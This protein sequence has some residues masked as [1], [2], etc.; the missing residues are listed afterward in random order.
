M[1]DIRPLVAPRSIAVIG[2]STNAQKS[3]GVLFHNL[4]RGGFAGPLYPI[5]PN[6]AEVMGRK[7]YASLADVPEHVDLVY[8][9][10]PRDHV[11][12]A[13]TQ[14]IAAGARAASIITAGFAEA[15]EAGRVDQERIRAMARGAGLLLG[16]PNTIGMVNAECGMMGSFV[17]FPRWET[18]G[19]SLFTQ[20][21]IFTGALM[22]GVMSAETQRLPV[23]KSIDVGNKIDVDELDFLDFVADDPG[24]SVIGFYIETILRP[25]AFLARAKQIRGSKPIVMLKPG[26]TADGA[27][28]SLAHT[29]SRESL[30]DSERD[31]LDAAIAEAG[32]IRVADEHEFVDTLR[33]LAYAPRPKGRRVAVATTSGALGVM[34]TDL[35]VE[36]GLTLSTF[37]PATVARMRT[38]LPDWLPPENPFDFW[39]GIDVKGP[40]EAHEVGLDAVM[41]DPNTD[42]VLATLLAPGNADFPE[43]GALIRRLRK[44]HDKPIVLAIYGGAARERW[45]RDIEGAGVPVLRTSREAA[46]ALALLAAAAAV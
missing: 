25:A 44:E 31:A 32:I 23:G 29:G 13:V 36:A 45:I 18:G 17:N 16:G 33:T 12:T 19:V 10:L 38:I 1:R 6:A 4:V 37:A 35:V 20:T 34:T 26:R 28:A 39:I 7:A 3:G 21:G 24:T 41:A 40:R 5:N 2:A 15:S 8:I 30:T 43:F 9:V 14:C 11:E 46:R 22:L 27:R 42:M